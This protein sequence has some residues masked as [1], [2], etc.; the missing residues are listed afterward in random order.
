MLTVKLVRGNTT[1]IVEAVEVDINAAG[2]P[3]PLSEE[4]KEDTQPR[5]M[6]NKVRAIKAYLHDGKEAWYYVASS[7]ADCG[8]GALELWDYAYIE[9]AHGATTEKVYAN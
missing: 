6:T 4:G 2:K 8:N 1:K 9:N 3:D 5:P 7:D